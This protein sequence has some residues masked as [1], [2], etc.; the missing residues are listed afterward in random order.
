MDYKINNNFVSYFLTL[1]HEEGNRYLPLKNLVNSNPIINQKSAIGN[2][3]TPP[4]SKIIS[5]NQSS[6]SENIFD[7]TLS[8]VNT[9][10][11]NFKNRKITLQPL[12][13]NSSRSSAANSPVDQNSSY[14]KPNNFKRHNT[15]A[16]SSSSS[17]IPGM[18]SPRNSSNNTPPYLSK[19]NNKATLFDFITTP[20]KSPSHQKSSNSQSLINDFKNRFVQHQNKLQSQQTNGKVQKTPQSPLVIQPNIDSPFLENDQFPEI[21]SKNSTQSNQTNQEDQKKV[22]YSKLGESVKNSLKSNELLKISTLSNFYCELILILQRYDEFIFF[23]TF[24]L[25][26]I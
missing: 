8:N 14:M 19:L 18:L 13:S 3:S 22:D 6:N 16:G 26:A 20:N 24:N 25:E 17:P 10:H 15:F 9:P 11:S 7:S 2:F 21:N 4:N 1:I 12:P 23:Q 5:L